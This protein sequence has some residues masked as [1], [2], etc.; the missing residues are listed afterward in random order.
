M[1]G[2]PPRPT[3]L[4]AEGRARMVDVGAKPVT[5]REAVASGRISMLPATA[6]AIRGGGV[7]K[8]DVLAVA[9]VAA[10]QAAKETS[11]TIPLCHPIPLDS[12]EV[13]LDGGADSVTARVTARTSA[14]T[15]VEMEAL[16]AVSAALLVVWDMVKGIDRTLE[17][18]PVR[19][20]EKRG[21]RSGE[22]RRGEGSP[23]A[24][25][26]GGSAR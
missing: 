22:W 1:P 4:D 6:D 3:H 14:R 15:G 13:D 5:R 21:G 10:I 16:T 9:R 2:D 17:I 19:L 24:P 20:E 26:D 25:R 8:G 12:V 7:G 23:P 11:R 18:G